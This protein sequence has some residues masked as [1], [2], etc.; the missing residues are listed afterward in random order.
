MND[1]LLWYLYEKFIFWISFILTWLGMNSKIAPAIFHL[2]CVLC[3]FFF[4]FEG[5]L[6]RCYST[7]KYDGQCC[8]SFSVV[9]VLLLILIVL[10]T[11]NQNITILAFLKVYC[12]QSCK[13][14]KGS[15]NF[16][17][18]MIILLCKKWLPTDFYGSHLF[19]TRNH[20]VM[21]YLHRE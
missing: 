5:T 16:Y 19:K 4:F 15:V 11:C 18:S 7:F 21:Y 1:C 9:N 17:K 3:V 2:D 13:K 14:W 10:I 8:L 12:S 20:L 6:N